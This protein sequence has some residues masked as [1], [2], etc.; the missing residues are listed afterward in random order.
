MAF[1]RSS[2]SSKDVKK[3]SYYVWFLGAKEAKGL[4]GDHFVLPVLH[5][6]LEQE[7][8]LEPSKVTLQVSNKGIKIVQNVP[9]K[10]PGKPCLPTS[11]GLSSCSSSSS[12]S[13]NVSASSLST[14]VNCKTEQIKHLIPHDSITCVVQEDDIVCCLLLIFNPVTKCPVHVHGYRCDSIETAVS[15]KESLQTLIDRPENQKKFIEIEKRLALRHHHHHPHHHHHE[16]SP[17]RIPIPIALPHPLPVHAI[18]VVGPHHVIY[19]ADNFPIPPPHLGAALHP[20]GGIFPARLLPTSMSPHR[21]SAG[22][23]SSD[24]RST[25][26]E[27]SDDSLTGR[28]GMY[29][30]SLEQHYPQKVVRQT[31]RAAGLPSSRQGRKETFVDNNNLQNEKK[32]KRG[33]H[34]DK[35]DYLNEDQVNE[36]EDDFQEDDELLH[37]KQEQFES[38]AQELKVKLTSGS[39][40]ILLPPRDYDTIS[41][42]RGNLSG[43]EKRKSTNKQIVGVLAEIKAKQA[44]RKEKE[45]A[46]E[47]QK[48][49]TP[50][51]LKKLDSHVNTKNSSSSTTTLSSTSR[52]KSTSETKSTTSKERNTV[53]DKK[54]PAIKYYF[55]GQK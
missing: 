15:L 9:K 32:N 37:Q 55:Y 31:S 47:I 12:S 54:G 21:K 18:P 25:R 1:R 29:P 24:G 16:S 3:A 51:D 35:R 20:S 4:R 49:M 33:H 23:S 28:N 19:H 11:T 36:D 14:G 40:P 48:G 10:P 2:S 41:R 39:G 44:A 46:L 13:N 50:V 27:E 22:G 17:H 5:Q 26:T 7:R 8:M 6:L 53:G 45:K 42:G 30:P 34:Y 52:S 38:L 43:I